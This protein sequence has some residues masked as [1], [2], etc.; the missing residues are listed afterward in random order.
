MPRKGIDNLIPPR[1]KEEARERGKNGGKASGEARRKKKALKEEL[2]LLLS[3]PLKS[4]EMKDN[5]KKIGV[6]VAD[7]MTIQT[8]IVAALVQQAGA[9]NVKAFQEIRETIMDK[10]DDDKKDGVVTEII[11]QPEDASEADDETGD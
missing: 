11:I 3:M 5:L 4:K 2:Q 6:D 10:S 7:G 9:G 8:A 1:T